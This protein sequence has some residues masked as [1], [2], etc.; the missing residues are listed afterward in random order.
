MNAWKDARI[1]DDGC[2][3]IR[4]FADASMKSGVHTLQQP[5]TGERAYSD[6]PAGH[7]G[8]TN[9][10]QGR[11]S[12]RFVFNRSLGDGNV[13]VFAG[14]PIGQTG[15]HATNLTL[16]FARCANSWKGRG[17]PA[18]FSATPGS[19][20]RAAMR[21]PAPG[22]KPSADSV[23]G[24]LGLARF[25]PRP[26]SIRLTWALLDLGL[27][28]SRAGWCGRRGKGNISTWI[29]RA[30]ELHSASSLVEIEGEGRGLEPWTLLGSDLR[31]NC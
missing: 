18:A 21:W 5:N 14:R 13:Q 26:G 23:P 3:A 12:G 24:G 11:R 29:P 25:R 7:G 31:R 16:T 1:G 6:D 8:S 27:T 9:S 30:L 17:L 10:G 22:Q 19:P 15:W 20:C 4:P 2:G 28:S